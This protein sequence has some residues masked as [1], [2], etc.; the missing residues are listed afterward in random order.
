MKA[1]LS[2]VVIGNRTDDSNGVAIN[3]CTDVSAA[4]GLDGGERSEI[5]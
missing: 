2:V 3:V 5:R 1:L 4:A